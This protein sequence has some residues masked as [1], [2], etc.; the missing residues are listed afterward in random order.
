MAKA[1]A[2]IDDRA[3]Q[4]RPRAVDDA[5]QD[6]AAE[7]IGAGEELRRRRLCRRPASRWVKG[8]SGAIA[9]GEDGADHD[10]RHDQRGKDDERRARRRPLMAF[11]VRTTPG[12]LMSTRPKRMRGSISV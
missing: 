5:R 9:P 7:E 12:T 11:R 4:R 10:H 6:V 8:E 3:D 2:A 1:P